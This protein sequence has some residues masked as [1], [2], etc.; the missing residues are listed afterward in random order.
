MDVVLASTGDAIGTVV[1]LYDGTGVSVQ[2]ITHPSHT[3]HTY[4]TCSPG[5][6]D[7]LRIRLH[8]NALAHAT[9][10]DDRWVVPRLLVSHPTSIVQ[11]SQ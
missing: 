4:T 6:H 11:L 10:S 1:S 3:S 8:E 2:T 5:T 9:G 7:V